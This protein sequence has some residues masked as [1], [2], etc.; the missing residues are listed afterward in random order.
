MKITV[1]ID[2]RATTKE[3]F[4]VVRLVQGSGSVLGHLDIEFSKLAPL[5]NSNRKALDFVLLAAAVYAVDKL[6]DRKTAGDNWTREF[7]LTVPVSDPS[8]WNSVHGELMQSLSFLT[9]DIWELTFI[10]LGSTLPRPKLRR[11]RRR[12][13]FLPPFTANI[14]SLFSGGLDSLVGVIDHLESSK[15]DK[16][17]LVGHHDGQ[18][19]GPLSDQE[20]IHA[21]LQPLAF[22]AQILPALRQQV[23]GEI[24]QR[25]AIPAFPALERP[26]QPA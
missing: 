12:R 24:G 11:R 17:L 13:A 21:Q 1:D 3:E 20:A 26:L 2:T 14:V 9:G 23:E 15:Q 25:P 16:M 22:L 18:M 4:A 8:A 6:V 19:A 5:R 10:P 7:E